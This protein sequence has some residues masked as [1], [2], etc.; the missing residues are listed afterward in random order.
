MAIVFLAIMLIVCAPAVAQTKSADWTV[1]VWMNGDNNL[2]DNIVGD[3]KE[4]ARLRQSDRVN[5]VVQLD[6]RQPDGTYRFKVERD[7]KAK[8][9]KLPDIKERNMV[10]GIELA[11]F[12]GWAIEHY[13]AERYALIFSSHGSGP[14]V[15]KPATSGGDGSSTPAVPTRAAASAD[16]DPFTLP[17]GVFGSPNRAISADDHESSR[18]DALYNS[19]IADAL[20]AG[21]KGQTLELIGFDACLMSMVEM[22][23]GVRRSARVFVASEELV[24]AD[25]WNYEEW[26]KALI[27]D[28]TMDGVAFGSKLVDTYAA[29]QKARLDEERRT[30]AAFRLAAAEDLGKAISALGDAVRAGPADQMDVV[31]SARSRCL[32]F[33]PAKC[34]EKKCF[35]H[36]DLKRFADLV[37]SDAKATEAVKAAAGHVS[38]L[39]RSMRINNYA[40]TRRRDDEPTRAAHGSEGLAIY[41]PATEEEFK[42]DKLTGPAY[43]KKGTTTHPIEFVEALNWSDFLQAYYA[44]QRGRP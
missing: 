34:G 19:E 27:A 30:L 23:Y 44:S 41:F 36:I 14:R 38:T 32:L 39:L 12:V 21:L 17:D 40:G 8:V 3:W 28:P 25:G 15:Y 26:L 29:V 22:A 37:A 35:H 11:Q 24:D 33:A 13:K 43:V 7:L 6:R 4:M 10:S 2:E 9:D 31:T 5:V 42:R 1:M 16:D 20:V 18:G